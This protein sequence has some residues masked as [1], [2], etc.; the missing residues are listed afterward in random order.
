MSDYHWTTV[1]DPTVRSHHRLQPRHF[2]WET[3]LL[4]E[5]G[6]DMPMLRCFAEPVEL[7]RVDA[8]CLTEVQELGQLADLVAEIENPL[9]PSSFSSCELHLE[10]LESSSTGTEFPV[11]DSV[12]PEVHSCMSIVYPA[13]PYGCRGP[14]GLRPSATCSELLQS[15]R[16]VSWS[17]CRFA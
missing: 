4:G 7:P 14:F 1:G 2:I 12:H 15:L 11:P 5:R 9:G 13:G 3:L 16:G 8:S 17:F 10:G 6:P